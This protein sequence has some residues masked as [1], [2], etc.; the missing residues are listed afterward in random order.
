MQQGAW[1]RE[2]SAASIRTVGAGV[3]TRRV[4]LI[5]FAPVGLLRCDQTVLSIFP[6][7]P[8]GRREASSPHPGR[9]GAP[10]DHPPS[11]C[12]K[13]WYGWPPVAM[14]PEERVSVVCEEIFT[15]QLTR[16]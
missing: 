11:A 6:F 16:P 5:H 1:G 12:G 10:P 7:R 3:A 13:C 4:R 14:A 2:I 8:P 15:L 9:D